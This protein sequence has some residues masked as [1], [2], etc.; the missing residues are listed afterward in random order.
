MGPAETVPIRDD[1]QRLKYN[2]QRLL[3]KAQAGDPAAMRELGD[4]ADMCFFLTLDRIPLDTVLVQFEH[5]LRIHQGAAVAAVYRSASE[6]QRVRCNALPRSGTGMRGLRDAWR[7][8]A[9]N[10]GELTARIQVFRATRQGHP[11]DVAAFL[12]ETL[13]SDDPR[14]LFELAPLLWAATDRRMGMGD[15]DLPGYEGY[16]FMGETPDALSLIACERGLDCSIGSPLMDTACV[17]GGLCG[18]QM[19]LPAHIISAGEASGKTQELDTALAR[20]HA[21]LAAAAPSG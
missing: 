15:G 6:R 7:T 14:A 5:S 21:L 10:A 9:A 19:D 18:V 1:L 16:E 3:D 8:R 2:V 11:A 17:G 12:D 13:A 20:M 4:I